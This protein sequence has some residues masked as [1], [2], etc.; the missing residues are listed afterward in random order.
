MQKVLFLTGAAFITILSGC[1]KIKQLVNINVDIP[2]NYEVAVP[3]VSGYSQA[4]P[5]PP[6]GAT[7][8]FPAVPVATNSQQYIQEYGT[9]S[10]L[11]LDVYLKSLAI[12]IQSP[13]NQYFDFLDNIDVYISTKTL[14]EMLIAS[15]SNVPKGSG[16]LTLIPDTAVNL[17]NYFL[18]DTIYFRLNTHINAVPPPGEDLNIM[19]VFH[20]LA[21]PLG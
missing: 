17:K 8:S 11:V 18:Q 21:N 3:P 10:N 2:Y 6:G 1:N 13:A 20:M 5:L 19:S 4:V 16:T 9:D 7:L 12:Q 15:Q 14:P